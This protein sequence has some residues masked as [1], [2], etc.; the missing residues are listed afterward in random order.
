MRDKVACDELLCSKRIKGVLYNMGSGVNF[1]IT[2]MVFSAII[3]IIIIIIFCWVSVYAG[4]RTLE[5]KV[6]SMTRYHLGQQA[7][8][9]L[10]N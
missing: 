3:I 5:V 2:H 9:F 7:R 1:T 4:A 6:T 8:W 10:C